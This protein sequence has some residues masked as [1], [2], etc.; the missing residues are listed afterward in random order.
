MIP[1]I[2]RQALAS[3]SARAQGAFLHSE[4]PGGCSGDFSSPLPLA[5]TRKRLWLLHST[6]LKGGCESGSLTALGAVH[7]PYSL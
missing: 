4:R 7:Y 1:P 6:N 2:W 5:A 3:I